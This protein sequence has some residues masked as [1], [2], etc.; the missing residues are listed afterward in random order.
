MQVAAYN[1]EMNEEFLQRSNDS[2]EAVLTGWDRLWKSRVWRAD[3]CDNETIAAGNLGFC[4]TAGEMKTGGQNGK[5]R[6]SES[7]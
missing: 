2:G 1:E 6:L 3:C 4:D 7:L 5:R